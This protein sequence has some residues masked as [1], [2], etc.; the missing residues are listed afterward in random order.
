MRIFHQNIELFETINHC[1][2]LQPEF[3]EEAPRWG[4]CRA[5]ARRPGGSGVQERVGK[6]WANSPAVRSCASHLDQTC[7]LPVKGLVVS[8]L[9]MWLK[10]ET[11]QWWAQRR[12]SLLNS[13][14]I[15]TPLNWR[16]KR[17]GNDGNMRPNVQINVVFPQITSNDEML[18]LSLNHLVHIK[19]GD[20]LPG[21]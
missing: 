11:K 3:M 10:Q 1:E 12:I 13:D 20:Y 18:L 2:S 4:A 5:A 7:C 14:F 15:R 8:S 21:K 9:F 17:D 6:T 19:P 16:P